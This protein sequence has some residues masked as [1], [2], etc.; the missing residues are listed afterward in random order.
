MLKELRIQ[1]IVL[2]ESAVI[3]FGPGFNVL[4]GETGSGKSSLMHAL[5]LIR[6]ERADTALI[7]RGAEKGSVEALFDI[8]SLPVVKELLNAAGIDHE[9]GDPLI[10][11]RDIATSG[12]GRAFVNNQAA[13]LTTLRALS[14]LLFDQIDQHAS[15]RLL[16]TENHRTLLDLYADLTDQA[17]AFSK[18]WE[19]EYQVKRKLEQLIDGSSQRL[20]EI[21]TLQ[22]ELEELQEAS[23]KDG[24][25]EELFAEYT[26]L[27][28]AD[29]LAAHLNS[30][31]QL[32]T[33]EK[34]GILPLLSR[35][36]ATVEKVAQIDPTFAEPAAS[37]QN[38][39]A[40]LQEAA[41][42]FERGLGRCES[43]PERT[44]EIN[45][46]L[47]LLN[48][49]KRKYGATVAEMQTYQDKTEERLKEL[50][51]ADETIGALQTQLEKLQKRN[52]DLAHALTQAR[53]KGAKALA[54]EL[55]PHL[56]SLN[57]PKAEFEI[58]V[59]AQARSTSGDDKVEFFLQP[60]VGERRLAIK[61]FASGG[62][63][64][65]LMLSLQALLAGKQKLPTLI[66]DEIDANIGGT[67]AA[68]VG[69]KL[70]QIGEKHQV[71]AITHF[72]QVAQH[73]ETHLQ[74]IKRERDGRTL[75]EIMPLLDEALR[76]QEL[77]R[78]RGES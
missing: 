76:Q 33:H 70:K 13:Q 19:E 10:L 25:E 63:L 12:K 15:R 5:E 21:E 71:I 46:R 17:T 45:E 4:S 27:T 56:R 7:R 8:D 18:S 14:Q 73:A 23:L 77:S 36:R 75:T 11:R 39:Y 2:V 61:D 30:L 20:R 52:Q 72:P 78:M 67:T 29:E 62:E 57:M 34:Q 66:F 3:P 40:E 43:Q 35:Q 1:N 37:L 59:I 48:R 50:E 65:R 42:A 6:G 26:R 22:R 53:K 44:A 28:H 68:V 47:A 38:A 58:D 69:E 16:T 55:T 32:L 54:K 49:L 51:N 9:E 74:I 41:Y 64:S 31:A 24:E 60:N